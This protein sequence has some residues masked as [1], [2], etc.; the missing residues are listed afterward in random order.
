VA[1]RAFVL[2]LLAAATPMLSL[3]YLVGG[4]T[5]GD[6]VRAV[7][8]LAATTVMIA[9]ITVACSALF[10][11]VQTATVVAYGVVL[12]LSL[13]SLLAYGIASAIDESRGIDAADPPRTILLGSPLAAVA[14]V[15][16]EGSQTGGS[17]ASSPFRPI[18]DWIDDGPSRTD[19][20]PFDPVGMSEEQIERLARQFGVQVPDFDDNGGIPFWVQSMALLGA[21]SLVSLVVASRRLRTPARTER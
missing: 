12:V 14:D 20:L 9:C 11:K 16:G 5:M 3:T 13:G 7:V 18:H 4:I 6:V 2:L 15:I 19:L 17:R 10:K 21:L 8:V 1:A